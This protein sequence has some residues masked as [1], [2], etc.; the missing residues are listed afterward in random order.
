MSL[1][2]SGAPVS[3]SNAGVGSGSRA[4]SRGA[5]GGDGG[6][7]CRKVAETFETQSADGTA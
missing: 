6:E 4:G 7:A 1:G 2:G 3:S 5:G